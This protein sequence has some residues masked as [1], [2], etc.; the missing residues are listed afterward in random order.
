MIAKDVA[1]SCCL[2]I[3]MPD[4]LLVLMEEGTH[5]WHASPLLVFLTG[6]AFLGLI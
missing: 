3:H 4:E 6:P 1:S 2:D 5:S